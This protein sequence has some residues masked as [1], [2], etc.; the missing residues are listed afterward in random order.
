MSSPGA[1]KPAGQTLR[2]SQSTLRGHFGDDRSA[3]TDN[4]VARL[5]AMDRDGNGEARPAG[6]AT[7][8]RAAPAASSQ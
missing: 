1:P 3:K 2:L 5:M 7:P 6:T 8:A 4:V